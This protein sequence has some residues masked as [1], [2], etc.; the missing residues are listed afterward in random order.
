MPIPSAELA[1]HILAKVPKE[2]A[3]WF[4]T[5]IASPTQTSADDLESFLNIV[6]TVETKSIEFHM[7]REDFENWIQMLG[8]EV[9]TRQIRNLREKKL[10]GEDLRKRLLQILQLRY[11]ILRKMASLQ[12]RGKVHS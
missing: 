6:K 11:G 12:T 3:F 2:K 10:T 1:A 5:G 7:G 4:Y 8:D 9:L